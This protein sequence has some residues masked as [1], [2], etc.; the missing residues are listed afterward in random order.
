MCAVSTRISILGG[1]RS[2]GAVGGPPAFEAAPRSTLR[3]SLI[4]GFLSL[5]SFQK[6]RQDLIRQT[7]RLALIE[8]INEENPTSPDRVVGVVLFGGFGNGSAGPTSDF[9]LQILTNNGSDL[10][11]PLFMERLA[12]RWGLKP[13]GSVHPINGSSKGF[14]PR[15]EVIWTIHHDPFQIVS[16][17]RRLESFLSPPEGHF[18]DRSRPEGPSVLQK[19]EWRIFFGLLQGAIRIDEIKNPLTGP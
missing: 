14:L 17:D 13:E 9:D 8:T 12:R 6:E 4:P 19:L 10:H 5:A 7:F 18:E 11:V 1:N 2:D 16:P 3:I 15:R